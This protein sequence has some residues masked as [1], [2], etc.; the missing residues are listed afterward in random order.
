MTDLVIKLKPRTFKEIIPLVALYRPGPLGSGMVDEYVNRKNGVTKVDYLLPE[1]RGAHLR[2]A[3]RDRLPGPGAAD[4]QQAGRLSASAKRICCAARWARRRPTEMAKQRERFVSGAVERNID[5]RE[6]GEGLRPDR[7][8]RRVRLREVA[9]DGLRAD[10]LP[11]RLSQGEPPARVPGGAAHRRVGQPRQADA[12]HRPRAREG[13]RDPAARRERVGAR[14]H[15]RRRGG[16]RFGFAGIKN[17][18]DGAIEAI[19]EA[20]A[21]ERGPLPQPLRLLPARRR[22]SA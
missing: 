16:I 8:V 5:K 18:G 6:G 15:G 19:V 3:R 20:R 17:V 7:R 1:L 10:H 21:D 2:D 11:D 4:R 14:L 12:L 13:H 9:L 22:A